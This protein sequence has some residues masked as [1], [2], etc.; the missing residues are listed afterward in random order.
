M[1][2]KVIKNGKVNQLLERLFYSWGCIVASNPWKVIAATLLVTGLGSLGLLNFSAE[3]NAWKM[4][5]PEG[6]RYWK[7]QE[8]KNEYFV[9][10]TRAT[11]T[12]LTHEE[13][14]L[15]PEALLLLLDLHE[16]V[17]AVKFEGGNYSRACMRIPVTNILLGGN[18]RRKRRSASETNATV[19][20]SESSEYH[21]F[22]DYFNFY[23]TDETEEEEDIEAET[24]E[25]LPKDIYCDVIETLEDKCGEY[26]LLEIW[27]YERAHISGLTEEDIIH[28]INTVEESPVFGYKTNYVNYLGRVERNSTGHVVGAK[29]IRNIWLEEFQPDNIVTSNKISGLQLD[30][31]DPFTLGYEHEVLK[32]LMAWRD[33]KEQE[34]SG[35]NL[36]MNL[37]LSF[38]TEAGG[39][40]TYDIRRQILGYI[41]MFTYTMLSLGNLNIVESKFFLAAAGILSVFFG[42]I[43]GIGLTMALGLPYTP[44]TGILPFICLGIGI[45][46]M[47]VIVRCLNNI[48]EETR[49]S[50]S[51]VINIGLAMKHAGASITITSVTD[52]FAFVTGAI[53]F[54]P[55]LQSLCISASIAIGAIYLF[56]VSWFVAWMVL[57]LKRIEQ[58]RDSFLPFIIHKDWKPPK[59]SRGDIIT[60]ATSKLSGLFRF[61]VFR[62][63]I[64]LLTTVFLSIGVWGMSQIRLGYPGV[65]LVPEDSYFKAWFHQ[66]EVDFPSDGFG[67]NFYTQDVSYGVQ[68]FEKIDM[69]VNELHNLTK[70]HNEWVHYGKD[71]PT[72]VQT[73]FEAS[74]G[75]WWLDFK[76]FL[77]KHMDIRNWREAFDI[78]L[79]PSY[80]SDFLHHKDGASYNK[81]FRFNEGL[82]CNSGAPSISAMKLGT[83]KIRY[84]EGLGQI[85]PAQQAINDILSKANLSTV[86]FADGY[87]YP[88]W[89]IVEILGQELYRNIAIALAC[90]L[91][92]VFITMADLTACL[93]TLACVVLTLVDVVGIIYALGMKIEHATLYCFVIG[94]GLSVDY[95]AH[96]AHAFIVSEGSSLKRATD[97]FT[98]ISPAILHGGISTFLAI[99]PIAFSQSHV[100]T[101]FFRMISLLVAF[102]LFHG[103]FFLPVMLSIFGGNNVK[104]GDDEK[105]SPQQI[106]GKVSYDLHKM[107]INSGSGSANPGF[108]E[109]GSASR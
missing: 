97:G 15:T 29:S 39:P 61:S 78:G 80:L 22:D 76:E 93:F 102:G 38:S 74:T 50:N 106:T 73:P 52:V 71:L 70:T 10:D 48:P 40:I 88:A 91:V 1:P 49:K 16:K 17:H 28:A 108:Q 89:E 100:F 45:D 107:N 109:D 59:W 67:V 82:K 3:T 47:F 104:D 32:I 58:K 21:Q 95:G 2:D 24:L 5:L 14:V 72:A 81:N 36:Y 33:E 56:Q 13:N 87:V 46:D 42:V 75:F 96:I 69:I 105:D 86:T 30:L 65:N 62:V 103:L 55:S 54:F 57:D 31:V 66:N 37:G 7:N 84:L 68:D 85:I 19:D 8:W 6:S 34:D 11:L 12:I 35:Y 101:T 77:E 63:F 90:V 20:W 60:I 26:S 94:I 23:G 79:F 41:L 64:L 51:H 92:I 44:T 43:V 25:G 4:L 98:S 53:T 9:E 83:L 27:Q 99:T 18:R